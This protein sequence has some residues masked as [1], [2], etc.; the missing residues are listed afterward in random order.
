[1]MRRS[2][3]QK[4]QADSPRLPGGPVILWTGVVIILFSMVAGLIRSF[5]TRRALP[6]VGVEYSTELNEMVQA[7]GY[8]A[9]LP[10]IRSAARIDF[11]NEAAVT[12]LLDSARQAG[13]DNLV[14]S[15][16]VALVRMKPEDPLV[17]NELVSALLSQGRVV[18]ALAH[19]K[20]AAR[21]SPNSSD[22]HCNIGA[23]LL[24]LGQK[25]EAASAYRRALELDPDSKTARLALEFPLR[26]F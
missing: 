19:G 6:S 4:P 5:V 25:H 9:T 15:A 18:E 14:V 2:R 12:G 22:V 8:T 11:D 10:H 24:G 1:M 3:A 21:L 13:D 7:R 20:V 16:L 17:R 26:G 23:A